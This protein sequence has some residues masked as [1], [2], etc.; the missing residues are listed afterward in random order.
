MSPN[1]MK[2]IHF[3]I[4]HDQK[5]PKGCK[6]Y[7]IQ[8]QS[9]PSQVVKRANNGSDCIG[10]KPKPQKKTNTKNLNDDKYWK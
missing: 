5:T 4:T 6:I 7:N 10:F 1:C 9:M 2:C 8:S 3:F